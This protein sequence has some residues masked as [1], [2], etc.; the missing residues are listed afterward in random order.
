MTMPSYNYN[1]EYFS[2]KWLVIFS[3]YFSLSEKKQKRYKKSV[4]TYLSA[5]FI[6]GST[7][8]KIKKSQ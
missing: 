7:E 4:L 5:L 2:K 6:N 8:L 1:F 3:F